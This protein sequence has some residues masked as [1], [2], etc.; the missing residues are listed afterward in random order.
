MWEVDVDGGRMGMG[1]S[2]SR[3]IFHYWPW[4]A[5]YLLPSKSF[6]EEGEMHEQKLEEGYLISRTMFEKE[7]QATI[8]QAYVRRFLA[9]K[10]A[11][12]PP[13]GIFFLAAKRKF[14][15]LQK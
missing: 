5:L 1:T 11:V 3:E 4:K 15:E 9:I 7:Y 14:E 13:D 6:E 8:I 10:R 12:R 2:T